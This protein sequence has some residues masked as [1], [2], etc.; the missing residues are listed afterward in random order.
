MKKRIYNFKSIFIF[1][2]YL[3]IYSSDALAPL[4]RPCSGSSQDLQNTPLQLQSPLI[5]RKMLTSE[6]EFQFWEETEV[7]GSQIWGIGWMFQQ[8]IEQIP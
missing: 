8:F 3:Y 4:S 5:R 2:H 6:E 1:Q 7:R